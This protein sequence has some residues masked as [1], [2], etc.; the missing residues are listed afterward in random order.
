MPYKD[1]G[2]RYEAIKKSRAK[3]PELYATLDTKKARNQSRRGYHL[4]RLYGITLDQWTKMLEEQNGRCKICDKQ[5]GLSKSGRPYFHLD[6]NHLTGK[7]RGLL[8]PRCNLFVGYIEKYND[9][10][11]LPLTLKYL[12]ENN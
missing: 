7:V 12:E 6:H 11:L 3:K 5:A 10:N 8:C 4:Q 2:K 9:I 1:K